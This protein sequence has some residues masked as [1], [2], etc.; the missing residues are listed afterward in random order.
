MY[1]V[2]RTDIVLTYYPS[3]ALLYSYMNKI[4]KQLKINRDFCTKSF[5]DKIN[6]VFLVKL[7]YLDRL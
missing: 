4:L 3:N 7:I 1:F 2:W 6:L 5:F